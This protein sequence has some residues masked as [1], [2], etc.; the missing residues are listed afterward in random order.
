MDYAELIA[1]LH[2][3]TQAVRGLG[4][5]VIMVWATLFFFN[6]QADIKSSIDSLVNAVRNIHSK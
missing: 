3:L 6:K 2:K 4:F 5:S 1:E